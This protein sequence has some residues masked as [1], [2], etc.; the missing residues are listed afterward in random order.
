M[1][2][3]ANKPKK[4]KQSTRSRLILPR[5]YLSWSGLSTFKR[6]KEE[7]IRHYMYGEPREFENSSMRFGKMFAEHMETGKEHDDPIIDMVMKSIKRLP[8]SEFQLEATLPSKWGDIRLLGKLDAYD[9][10]SHD[11][12]EYKT[13]KRKWTASM[14]QKH[15]QNKFYALCL[16]LNT[17]VVNQKKNLIWIE[18]EDG[19]NGEMVPTGNVKVFP[20]TYTIPDLITFGNEVISI[21]KQISDIYQ[22][23]I[24]KNF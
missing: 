7:Y 6:S 17:G 20:V 24:N 19:E 12:D 9:P 1:S 14:A 3:I 21:A 2:S 16:W 11:F 4:K 15:G 23:E 22:E 13:G 18:T 8:V 5:D 10:K